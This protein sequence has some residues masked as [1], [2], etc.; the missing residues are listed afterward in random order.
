MPQ[1]DIVS[2]NSMINVYLKNGDLP[3]AEKLYR[4]MP[5]RSIVSDSAMIDGYAKGGRVY[6]ARRIFDVMPERNV[7]SWTSLI[8][9]YLRI[10]ETGEARCLFDLMPEKNDVSWSTM[11]LGYARNGLIDKARNLF[12]LMPTRNVVSW[13]V[14]IQS[15]VEIN[16][17]DEAR[18]LFDEMPFRNFYSWNALILG[19]LYEKRVSEAIE[20]FK[21]VPERN[22]VS[23]TIMVTG[24]AQ[25]GLV[26][27]AREY[28]DQMPHKDIA[29]WNAMVSAYA[30]DGLIGEAVELFN[31]MHERNTITWNVIIGGLCKNELEQE[32]LN[33][34]IFMLRSYD[35]P[36]ETTFT[37]IVI[38]CQSLLELK[39]VHALLISL[40]FESENSIVNSLVSMYSKSGDVTDAWVAFKNLKIKD[41]V[42]WSVMIKAYSNHG[43]GNRALQVF[44]RMLRSGS[45]PDNITFVGVLSACSHAGLLEKG[46]KIFSSMTSAYGLEPKQE[47]YS[48]LVDLLG[49]AG[50]VKEARRVVSQM[51]QGER[52]GA[53]LGALLGACK[54]HGNI[55]MANQIGEE[56]IKLEPT[57]S[58]GY[59]LLAS[60]YAARGKWDEFALV[61]K[62]M[63]ERNVRKVP[64]YSQIEVKNKCHLFLVGDR[65][66]QQAKEIYAMLE[67]ILVPEMKDTGLNYSQLVHF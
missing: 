62:K 10:G 9:G 45:R 12:D 14:M 36:N 47:H 21:L 29:A 52:D 31:S 4:A 32:A 44:S 28:F 57:S 63:K 25:N 33:H 65:S 19:Y 20:L 55:E 41:V 54:L 35:R 5:G 3:N 53:V 27:Q 40:G 48:C 11:V 22:K 43:Y 49:R 38:A 15:Y 61:K 50:H 46:R 39:Q 66:H 56:L 30:D 59:T 23:W 6:E 18:R 64:G 58:G 67:E 1:R 51:P 2:F 26:K 24:L 34:F 8:S 13:T 7:Y 17:I 37:I 60:V 16:R 42:S